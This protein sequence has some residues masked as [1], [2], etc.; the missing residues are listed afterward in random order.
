MPAS[1]S[2]PSGSTAPQELTKEQVQNAFKQIEA[3]INMLINKIAELEQEINEHALVLKAFDK[4]EPTRRC[5]R[6][7]GGVL[8]ERTV[9]EVKPAIES[10]KEKIKQ[11]VGQ[12]EAQLKTKTAQ[13]TEFIE[14][15]GLNKEQTKGGII[16]QGAAKSASTGGSVLV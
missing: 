14:K 2:A 4:V 15:H 16:E 1:A 9:A 3:E 6:M 10:N 11:A 8:V 5:F 12:I 7:I 13:R